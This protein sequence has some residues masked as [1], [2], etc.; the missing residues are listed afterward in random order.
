V[1]I[2]DSLLAPPL[3]ETLIGL[4]FPWTLKKS[5]LAHCSLRQV[6][7]KHSFV[8]FQGQTSSKVC[9]PKQPEL[10]D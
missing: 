9:S 2:R 4:S 1:I 8:Y 10:Q 6:P 5:L 3:K 7:A